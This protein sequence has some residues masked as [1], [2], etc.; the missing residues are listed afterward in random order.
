[1][2]DV[3]RLPHARIRGAHALVPAM[4]AIQA[5][6]LFVLPNVPHFRVKMA[7]HA[8]LFSHRPRSHA[9]VSPDFPVHS[10]KRMSMNAALS[11]VGMAALV[12]MA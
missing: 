9:I 5:T 4:L 8:R 3:H 7:A 12:L 10:V 11:L 6:V 1:M 2:V